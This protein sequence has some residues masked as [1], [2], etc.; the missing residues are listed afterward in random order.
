[1]KYD[2][3]DVRRELSALKHFLE[4]EP[5]EYTG[6]QK[7]LRKSA[8]LV[9]QIL[10]RVSESIELG[11]IASEVNLNVYAVS[12]PVKNQVREAKMITK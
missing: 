5:F 7:N 12:D 3:E 4:N 11:G 8:V 2:L 6:Y 10:D 9:A 1:M